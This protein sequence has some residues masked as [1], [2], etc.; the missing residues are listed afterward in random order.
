MLNEIVANDEPILTDNKIK[1]FYKN[2]LF[3]RN[4]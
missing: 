2:I 3:M 1:Y 4:M